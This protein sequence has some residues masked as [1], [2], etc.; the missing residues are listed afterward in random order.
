MKNKPCHIIGAVLAVMVIVIL[1]PLAMDYFIIGNNVPSNVSNENW[2]PFFGSYFGGII[3]AIA[4]MCGIILTIHFS[5]KQNQEDHVLQ[6]RPY[7]IINYSGLKRKN[8]LGRI[9]IEYS[10][11]DTDGAQSQRRYIEIKNIGLG[12]A[13]EIS[14]EACFEGKDKEQIPVSVK[15]E[16]F[17]WDMPNALPVGE[18]GVMELVLDYSLKPITSDDFIESLSSGGEVE[19]TLTEQAKNRYRDFDIVIIFKYK[20]LLEHHYSQNMVMSV[21]F[22]PN[23]DPDPFIKSGRYNCELSLKNITNPT[24]LKTGGTKGKTT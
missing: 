6:I 11:K 23:Y 13:I 12:P 14:V 7:C 18:E 16:K 22:R 24:P 21:S 1:L 3:G 15:K 9:E 10:P 5:S 19:Y 17:I 20:D 2:V 8:P 4:S